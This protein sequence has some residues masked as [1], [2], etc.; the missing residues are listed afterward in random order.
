MPRFI[1]IAPTITDKPGARPVFRAE[2]S[3]RD[4]RIPLPLA[5]KKDSV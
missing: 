2:R 4:S 5:A 3:E 1:A